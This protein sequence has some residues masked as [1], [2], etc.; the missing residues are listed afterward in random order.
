MN[1]DKCG[2]CSIVNILTNE[3]KELTRLIEILRDKNE[4]LV[5]C[6]NH[7]TLEMKNYLRVLNKRLNKLQN[8]LNSTRDLLEKY[9]KL[10]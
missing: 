1:K 8:S 10:I 9:M 2:E 3:K 4:E 5:I 6:Y 7:D